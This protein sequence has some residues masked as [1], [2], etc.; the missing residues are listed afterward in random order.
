MVCKL[1][2]GDMMTL[3]KHE[4]MSEKCNVPAYWVCTCNAVLMKCNNNA[5]LDL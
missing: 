3:R 2:T 4:V 1:T 5:L